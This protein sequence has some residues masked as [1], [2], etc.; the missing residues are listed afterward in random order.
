MDFSNIFFD[1]MGGLFLSGFF[2][3]TGSK[4]FN[5]KI[6]KNIKSLLIIIGLA[7]FTATNYMILDNVIKLLTL[8]GVVL[9]AY[10]LLFKVN[11]TKCSMVSLMSYL[12]LVVS[13]MLFILVLTILHETKVI[14][15]VESFAGGILA[16]FCISTLSTIIALIISKRVN[17]KIDKVK[18]NNKF[19]LG[20]TFAI[21]LLAIGSL[22][23]KM[24][25]NDWKPDYSF[26]LNCII[27]LS[28]VCLGFFIIKQYLDKLKIADEYE[29][30][31]K[32][33]KETENLV[34]QYSICQHENRNEL[35]LIR[36]MVKKSNTKLLEY[37]DESIG[38]KDNIENAWIRYLRY[39][40]FGGLKGIIHNKLSNMNDKKINVFFNISKDVSESALGLLNVKENNQLSKIIGVFLDNAIE[41]TKDVENKEISFCI[42]V[43]DDKVVFEIANTYKGEVNVDE[44]YETGNSTKGKGHG[45]GLALV[46]A[47]VS[48]S[49]I[50]ENETK[51]LG[52]Y[53]VQ[54]LIVSKEQD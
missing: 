31:V 54:K 7:I 32:Y 6:D 4:F 51:T 21:L 19:S 38:N 20:V 30:Y 25:I 42:Y 49:S 15:D 12:L 10:K 52:D 23:Y 45:Y 13:E 33:S 18:E 34:E 17:D 35:I 24:N 48:E 36:G 11:F 22:L 8:Y 29:K 47:I 43:Q 26:V 1:I 16:N 44:I 46:K 37:L 5:Q 2:V 50:F 3:I 40:P 39:L 41:A 27:I 53:F 28:L 9:V 14:N